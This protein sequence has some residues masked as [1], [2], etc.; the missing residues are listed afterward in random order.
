MEIHSDFLYGFMQQ[1]WC[2]SFGF[3]FDSLGRYK[4]LGP[5]AVSIEKMVK[6]TGLFKK[7][8]CEYVTSQWRMALKQWNFPLNIMDLSIV[9]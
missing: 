9:V 1:T 3:N 2:V 4:I 8:L 6:V 7:K 5:V